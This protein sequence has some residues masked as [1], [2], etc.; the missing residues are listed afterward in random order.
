MG[1][2]VYCIHPKE[3]IKGQFSHLPTDKHNAMYAIFRADTEG[4]VLGETAHRDTVR[5]FLDS[6]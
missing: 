5:N 2:P 3:H 1:R 6:T 4:T